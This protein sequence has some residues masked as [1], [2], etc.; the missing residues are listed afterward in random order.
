MA[1]C[2]WLLAS[3]CPPAGALAE[4]SVALHASLD[5]TTP[6]HTAIRLNVRIEPHGELVPPPV[7]D[8]DLR[9]PASL[10]VQLS[11]LG[12]DA[13]SIARLEV[14]GLQACPANS[15]MGYGHAVA[16]LPIKHEAFHEAA[17]LAIVRTDEQRGH[18]ALLFYVYGETALSAEIVLLV[19]LLPAPQP[20][21]GQLAIHLPLVPTFVNGPYVGVSELSLVLGPDSLTYYERVHHKVVRY[22]PAGIPLPRHCPHGGFRFA[23]G[24][25][26]LDQSSARSSTTAPCP[27]RL[28]RAA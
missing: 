26:F 10:D 6:G 22:K 28:K 13:C 11:G 4:P 9:Y 16:A 15:L 24:L 3:A 19:E 25:S 2:A 5:P 12:V 27:A 17:R 18:P 1:A 8:G 20:Y 14:F 23:V 21:G 7:M